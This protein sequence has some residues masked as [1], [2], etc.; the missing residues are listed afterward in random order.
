LLDKVPRNL[1]VSEKLTDSS[2]AINA[3]NKRKATEDAGTPVSH[4][5]WADVVK[6]KPQTR[7]KVAFQPLK[8]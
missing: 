7:R 3:H 6:S 2:R 8:Q 5:S 1:G 4:P